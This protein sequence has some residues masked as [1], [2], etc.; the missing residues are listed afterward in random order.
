M[1]YKPLKLDSKGFIINEGDVRKV[2]KH[3]L[4][5]LE[6]ITDYITA[7]LKNDIQSIFIR[8][9]VSKGNAVK[10]YSDMDCV[11]VLRDK[12]DNKR[13]IQIAKFSKKLEKQYPYITLVDITLI[14]SDE[15]FNSPEYKRLQ[16]YLKTES[17]LL[18][19]DDIRKKIPSVKPNS[20]L[21]KFMYGEVLF[22]LEDLKKMFVNNEKREY[23]GRVKETK[24]WCIWTMRTI[25]RSSTALYMN[26]YHFYSQDL[27]VCE[28]YG[29]KYLKNLKEELNEALLL[30][31]HPTSNK[32]YLVKYLENYIPK[33]RLI[34]EKEV[35]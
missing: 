28:Y 34:W 22:E 21:A 24:F 10:H 8:G 13:K 15:L 3:Y 32:K 4:I 31:N 5:P 11:V 14:T 35:L 26:K 2:Q 33:F 17:A 29:S 18:M 7:N 23:L 27:R 9:S 20:K 1:I 16:I 6:Q 30:A 25:L 19:G 12:I